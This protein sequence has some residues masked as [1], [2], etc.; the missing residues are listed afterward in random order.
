LKKLVWDVLLGRLVPVLIFAFATFTLALR[1]TAAQ[2]LASRST[3]DALHFGH[4]LLSFFFFATTTVAYL[5][6]LPRRSGRRGPLVVVVVLA[7]SFAALAGAV[8]PHG[9]NPALELVGGVLVLLGTSYSVASV[10]HLRRSFSL[11]PE[12][13]AL[14]TTGPY[15]LS[16]HPLYLGET[17]AMIGIMLP[18]AHGF[19]LLIVPFA[20][21]QMVRARW[22]EAVLA[23]EFP[24]YAEYAARVPRYLPFLR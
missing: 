23:A 14:V 18:L 6:R 5:T 24:E 11:L 17:V 13:R 9:T 12:A 7:V 2:R 8:L 1:A 19:V 22:E 4:E 21:G 10:M 3:A 15:A 16:R 20:L